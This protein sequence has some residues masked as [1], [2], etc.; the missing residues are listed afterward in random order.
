MTTP[1]VA[2]HIE[3]STCSVLGGV[4]T[5]PP[6]NLS[7]TTKCQ[8]TNPS[9][10]PVP[11]ISA[12]GPASLNPSGSTPSSLKAGSKSRAD[13]S[14]SVV[15]QKFVPLVRI[16]QPHGCAAVKQDQISQ[17][18]IQLYPRVYVDAGV[19]KWKRYVVKAV[20][21]GIISKKGDLISLRKEWL[22]SKIN[23]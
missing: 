19:Q 20:A 9:S 5:S 18:I 21:A 11:I 13:P 1:H 8:P 6:S 14:T 22:N 10:H 2:N 12:S 7:A 15:S 3:A 17:K 23:P 16:L 4:L